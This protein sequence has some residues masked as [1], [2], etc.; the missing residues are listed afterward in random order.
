[1]ATKKA[2][3]KPKAKPIGKLKSSRTIG[4]PTKLDG[5]CQERFIEAVR[6]GLPYS[7]AC[8]L[9]GISEATL[10]NWRI[11]AEADSASPYFDF[12]KAVKAAEAEAEQANLTRIRKAADNG[13]WQA[14]AWILERRHPDK[15]GRTERQEQTHSGQVEIVVRRE[16]SN[17]TK[18]D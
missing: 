8:A 12:I 11:K 5:E 7:T 1:M 14:S 16:K 3:P 17:P 15:W 13:Q 9:A 4:R 2:T 10:H 18:T 6:E